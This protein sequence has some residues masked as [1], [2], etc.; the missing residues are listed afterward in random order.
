MPKIKFQTFSSH[1][2]ISLLTVACS[3]FHFLKYTCIDNSY[4][5]QNGVVPLHFTNFE[6]FAKII[7]LLTIF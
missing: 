1:W 6:D 4:K 2:R 3:V 5:L 7:N